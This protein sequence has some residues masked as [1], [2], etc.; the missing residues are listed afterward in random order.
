MSAVESPARGGDR[1]PGRGEALAARI[2]AD[3]AG[4]DPGRQPHVERAEDVAPAQR[5]QEGRLGQRGGQGAHG[6]G[7]HLARLGVGG[8][9]G[10]DHDALAVGVV[11]QQAARRLELRRRQRPRPR[12]ARRARSRRPRRR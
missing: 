10:H 11:G 5:R 3:P 1:A 12:G 6:L 2:E 4:Q 7:G 9:A 8:P